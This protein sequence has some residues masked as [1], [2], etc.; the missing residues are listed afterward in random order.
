MNDFVGYNRLREI[1][2]DVCAIGRSAETV[3]AE[4]LSRVKQM[5]DY[6]PIEDDVTL[7][8]IRRRNG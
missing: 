8:V 6:R 4:I 3:H 5:I 2:G 1:V 7:L